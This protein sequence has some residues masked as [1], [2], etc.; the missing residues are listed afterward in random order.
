MAEI[1]KK[2]FFHIDVMPAF[3]KMGHFIVI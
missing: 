2:F 3:L 1:T